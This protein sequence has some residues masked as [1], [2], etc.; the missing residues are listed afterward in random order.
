MKQN[1]IKKIQ[2][3]NTKTDIFPKHKCK[4]S[5][6]NFSKLNPMIHKKT[7]PH[8]QLAFPRNARLYFNIPELVSGFPGGSAEASS[9]CR[10]MGLTLDPGRS[11]ILG[12]T[13]PMCHNY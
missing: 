3:K 2:E 4:S 6:Q 5:K 7:I 10:D 8:D 1:Q 9:Q 11:H 12:A 13:K